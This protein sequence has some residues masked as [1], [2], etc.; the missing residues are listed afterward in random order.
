[1]SELDWVA[2]SGCDS[3]AA[4]ESGV[5]DLAVAAVVDSAAVSGLVVEVD[6]VVAV[7]SVVVVDEAGWVVVV[8]EETVAPVATVSLSRQARTSLLVMRRVSSPAA[9]TTASMAAA[10]LFARA[11]SVTAS[12]SAL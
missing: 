9:E 7:D 5:A 12:R 6:S 11:S 2:V 8:G 1:V 4:D 10:G 3:V